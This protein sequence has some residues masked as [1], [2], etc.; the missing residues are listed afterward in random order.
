LQNISVI[1]PTYNRAALL[2]SAIDS[3]LAQ[4]YPV[5]EIIVVDD[6]STDN[7]FELACEMQG[8][9]KL[10][11]IPL[12]L[13]RQ[14]QGGAARARNA[15][16]AASTG[17]WIAFL[18]SD[19]IWLPEKL[20]FQ[21]NAL[22]MAPATCFACVTDAFFANNPDLKKTAFQYAGI[23]GGDECRVI[24]GATKRIAYG[25][26]GLYVQALLIEKR[27]ATNLGGFDASFAL[28][29][30]SDFF[31]RLSLKT[32]IVRVNRA[33]VTID[34]TPNRE[35]GLLEDAKNE[36]KSFEI[37]KRLHEK[38]LNG[39]LE[40]DS[41]SKGLMRKRLHEIHSGIASLHL[42]DDQ[43]E[44]A[45]VSLRRAMKYHTS[46]KVLTKWLLA[47]IAPV[48]AKAVVIKTRDN[49]PVQALL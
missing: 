24:D 38:W 33:L 10:K 8:K 32:P 48:I 36:A 34:R 23:D 1:I 4:T 42:I 45:R 26:H 29:E 15:G 19:D 30:D 17:D 14:Q 43:Y 3:V 37:Q 7:T 16:I 12:L 41:E 27:L 46:R 25:Y 47:E 44:E 5:H 39:Q 35:I 31:L 11:R 49:R 40:I 18:D 9:V 2:E 22:A 28:C 20:A 13:V 21:V 6:G